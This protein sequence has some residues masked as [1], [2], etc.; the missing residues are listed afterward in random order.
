MVCPASSCS[1]GFVVAGTSVVSEETGDNG[2]FALFRERA[3]V[4]GFARCLDDGWGTVKSDFSPV[5]W[6]SDQPHLW[7]DANELC[8]SGVVPWRKLCPKCTRKCLRTGLWRVLERS[9]L[10]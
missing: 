4:V 3:N 6:L 1:V 9:R 10:H 5:R 2:V 7:V 8:V